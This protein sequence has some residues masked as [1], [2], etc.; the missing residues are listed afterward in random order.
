M[1]Y[2]CFIGLTLLISCNNEGTTVTPQQDSFKKDGTI[3]NDTTTVTLDTFQKPTKSPVGFYQTTLPCKD[4]KG[5]EH[6]VL[7]NPDLTYRLE[8]KSWGKNKQIKWEGRWQPNGGKIWLYKGDTVMHRYAWQGDTLFYLHPDGKTFMLNKPTPASDNKTW[9]A[10]GK[11]GAE[12]F[13]VGNEPFWNIEIDEQKAILFH[14]AEWEKPKSFKAV[15]P[16]SFADSMVY[17]VTS[18]SATLR[19][20]VYNTF[21]SDG[22]SDY[23]Y[24]NSV[25]VT[26]NNQVYNGCGLKYQ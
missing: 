14:L 7:F 18:D 6:T 20:T 23:I 25:R 1:R 3:L 5:I 10:K 21:C 11:A 8:E 22:M 19:V 24:N 9:S 13:G 4:C 2:L 26:Y 16:V 12:F 17:S 15:K